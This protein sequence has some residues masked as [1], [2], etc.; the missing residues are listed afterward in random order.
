MP[1][2]FGDYAYACTYWRYGHLEVDFGADLEQLVRSNYAAD[3][4]G[5]QSTKGYW[6]AT[7]D[8]WKSADDEAGETVAKIRAELAE[9]AEWADERRELLWQVH[10]EGP[11]GTTSFESRHATREEAEAAAAGYPPLVAATV[12]HT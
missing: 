9:L 1:T 6:R 7:D 10:I 8:G 12:R 4:R 11:S 5:E 3:E 2:D